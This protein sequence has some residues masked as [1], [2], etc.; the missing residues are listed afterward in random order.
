[1]TSE[2]MYLQLLDML[3]CAEGWISEDNDHPD[4]VPDSW[5]DAIRMAA[6]AFGIDPEPE[7]QHY[8]VEKSSK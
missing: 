7:L 6:K 3:E 2:E 8:E 5:L 1:M 4:P